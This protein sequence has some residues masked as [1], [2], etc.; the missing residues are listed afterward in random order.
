MEGSD[1]LT[2]EMHASIPFPVVVKSPAA[3]LGHPLSPST[4]CAMETPSTLT[5]DIISVGMEYREMLF[6]VETE[7]SNKELYRIIVQSRPVQ[8]ISY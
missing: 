1:G 3:S 2:V 4:P 8:M 6:Q 7:R 5:H